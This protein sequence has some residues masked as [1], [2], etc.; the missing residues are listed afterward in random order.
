MT[1]KLSKMMLS[2]FFLIAFCAICLAVLPEDASASENS[3]NDELSQQQIEKRFHEINSTYEVGEVFS[4]SD[5]DFV[6]QY[7]TRPNAS[8]QRG[9]QNFSI[10]GGGYGTYVNASGY[11][12]HNGTFNYTYGANANIN[13]TSGGTPRSM[14]FTV[15]CTSYGVI[16]DQG[17]GIIYNDG[18]SYTSTYTNSFY[19]NPSRTYTGYMIGYVVECWVDVTTSD[20]NYFTVHA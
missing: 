13:K 5:A 3:Q 18:T 15:H 10:G 20:G 4:S 7:S 19:A 8:F 6:L 11:I 16:G 1:R 14:T 2:A 12:Y 9:G 17:I